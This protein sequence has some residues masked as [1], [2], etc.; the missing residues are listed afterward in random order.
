MKYIIESN[1]VIGYT[2]KYAMLFGDGYM[3]QPLEDLDVLNSDYINEHYG[4]L[5]DTAY[6]RGFE[7]G[8]AV[9]DKG[10]EG[11]KYAG[12]VVTGP[13]CITCCN[14]YKNQWAAKDDKIEVGDEVEWTGDKYIVTYI[15]Y[16]IDTS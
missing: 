10:C 16:N 1:D 8:K 6:Q 5:Q 2:P 9:N 4:D 11:C 7:Y 12:K 14:S 13:P 3:I 15:N